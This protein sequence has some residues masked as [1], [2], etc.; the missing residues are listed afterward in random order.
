MKINKRK[1]Q[2][3]ETKR[4][5]YDNAK[6]L[7]L[8]HG[9][10]SVSVDSIVKA[11]GVAKGSF[12]V[13]FESKDNLA[14]ILLT[15]YVNDVD[16]EYKVFLD[17]KFNEETASNLLILMAEKIAEVIEDK[18]GYD[19]MK[20][21]YK[22]HITNTNY[23]WYSMSYNRKLYKMFSD[24]LEKGID[25]EEFRTDISVD[26]LANHLILAMRGITFEWCIRY[27][28]VNLKEQY[29]THYKILLNGIIKQ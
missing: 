29:L 13:H 17:S 3:A 25:E 5:L 6:R 9:A 22:S 27:P 28:D 23:T 10:D 19:K 7:F 8:E 14:S 2:A 18:I 4:K 26:T 16:S 24:I 11:A 1:I 15:D 20:V 21:L 12:Y